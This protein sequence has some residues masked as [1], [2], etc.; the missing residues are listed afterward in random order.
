MKDALARINHSVWEL[1]KLVAKHPDS[2]MI[3]ADFLR[4]YHESRLFGERRRNIPEEGRSFL[5]LQ[6][7]EA[8]C[9]YLLHGIGGSPAEMRPLGEHLYRSGH[10]VYGARLALGNDGPG[11]RIGGRDRRGV[12]RIPWRRDGGNRAGYD[13]ERCVADADV[14]LGALLTFSPD[15]CALGFSFGGAVALNLLRDRPL[16]GAVLIAPGLFPATDGRSTL[17]SFLR[18]L[19]PFV[20]REAFPRESALL[21]FA[22][23][24]RARV[25]AVE[26][27]VL[28]IQ[29]SRDRVVSPRG[30]HYIKARAKH[31]KS[32]FELID[33]S[34]HVL[35]KG[36]E[37]RRVYPL[38]V[39]F[40]KEI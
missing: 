25:A 30:F 35:V 10:T 7:R 39:D 33:S 13:W 8:L 24:T 34:N 2:Y 20:A 12:A 4:Y 22:E 36:D 18:T 11:D 21:E 16:K 15:V 29:A 31:P 19:A 6:E 32:R 5:M 28:V 40:L 23:R 37:A 17:F 3:R 1:A 38:C 27:P 9:C 14:V 26:Q